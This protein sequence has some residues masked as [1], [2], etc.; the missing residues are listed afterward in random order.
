M[1]VEFLSLALILAMRDVAGHIAELVDLFARADKVLEQ[2][3]ATT[4]ARDVLGLATHR[5]DAK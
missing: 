2:A 1:L 4:L 3:L 5:T